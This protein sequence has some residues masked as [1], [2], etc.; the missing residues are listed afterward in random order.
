MSCMERSRMSSSLP[1]PMS[2]RGSGS[3]RICTDASMTSTPAVRASSRSSASEA[4]AS[5][6]LFPLPPT[7]TRMARSRPPVRRIAE[8][9]ANSS[10]RASGPATAS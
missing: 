8:A 6:R 10:S 5:A 3:R 1:L 4:S 2:V 9:R 7:P